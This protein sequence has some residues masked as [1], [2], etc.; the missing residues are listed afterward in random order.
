MGVR[1]RATSADRLLDT[2]DY[3]FFAQLILLLERDYCFRV[4][5]EVLPSPEPIN[6]DFI[7][8][9]HGS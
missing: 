8:Y 3:A 9:C 1:T 5:A 4:D 2:L 6:V 7:V